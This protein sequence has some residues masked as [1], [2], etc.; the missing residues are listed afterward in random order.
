MVPRADPSFLEKRRKQRRQTT[1]DSMSDSRRIQTLEDRVMRLGDELDVTRSDAAVQSLNIADIGPDHPF[2]SALAKAV[3]AAEFDAP[4]P[5]I[6]GSLYGA[7]NERLKKRIA[8][9]EAQLGVTESTDSQKDHLRAG[10]RHALA[11][12]TM[13]SG[14]YDYLVTLLATKPK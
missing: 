1:G 14:M 8:E 9:L 3:V 11:T 2:V 13:E 12:W 7:E 10:I 4:L 6:S 5:P